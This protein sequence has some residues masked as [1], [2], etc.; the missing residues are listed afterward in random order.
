ME[1]QKPMLA[2]QPAAQRLASVT[3]T[4]ADVAELA[5]GRS[6]NAPAGPREQEIV[7]YGEDFDADAISDLRAGR[8]ATV[9]GYTFCAETQMEPVE[10]VRTEAGA[11]GR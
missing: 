9:D 1:S 7:V 8:I 5:Q 10:G 4:A 2:D 3:L 11:D 6:I